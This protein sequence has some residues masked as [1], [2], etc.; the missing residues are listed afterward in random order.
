MLSIK[1]TRKAAEAILPSG[2]LCSQVV[3]FQNEILCIVYF[4][5][6]NALPDNVCGKDIIF[7]PPEMRNQGL[8]LRILE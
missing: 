7:F 5:M 4:M 1:G 2:Y 3:L 8:A 6:R